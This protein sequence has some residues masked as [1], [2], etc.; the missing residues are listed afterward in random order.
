MR[1]Y[2]N[3]TWIVDYL[4]LLVTDGYWFKVQLKEVY[5]T[6]HAWIGIEPIQ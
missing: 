1:T 3:N 4:L 2:T 6:Y 5:L